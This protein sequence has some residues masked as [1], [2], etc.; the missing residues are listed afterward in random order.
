MVGAQAG[1]T[2]SVPPGERVSGYPA[3]RHSTAK[4]LYAF[5]ENLPRL[6][7]R[8]RSLEKRLAALDGGG[9]PRPEKED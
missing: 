3:R 8:V 7:G 9:G 1:V 5:V 4:R 6:A 2:K